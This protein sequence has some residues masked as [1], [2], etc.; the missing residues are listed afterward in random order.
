MISL[1]T[2]WYGFEIAI[3]PDILVAYN[4]YQAM[5]EIIPPE[6]IGVIFIVVGAIMIPSLLTGN[7]RIERFAITLFIFVWSFYSVSFFI[8]LPE[9]TVKIFGMIIVLVIMGETMEDVDR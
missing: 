7:K 2:V 3:H 6:K 9:N 4:I 5:Q 1:A 8:A